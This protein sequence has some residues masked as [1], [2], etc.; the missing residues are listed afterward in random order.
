M[1]KEWASKGTLEEFTA[2]ILVKIPE[3]PHLAPDP[4]SVSEFRPQNFYQIYAARRELQAGRI[5]FVRHPFVQ[6]LYDDY[7][8]LINKDRIDERNIFERGVEVH[9]ARDGITLTD[10][11]Y[12]AEYELPDDTTHELLWYREGVTREQRARGIA[13]NLWL[14]GYSPLD[15][16]V[17]VNPTNWR[18]VHTYE[19]DHLFVRWEGGNQHFK[20]F[21]NPLK[22]LHVI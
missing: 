6:D 7:L 17:L 2:A 20:P 21:P 22:L 9:T 18:S 13:A 8:K 14:N 11:S 10:V 16:V 1:N 5:R 15:V 4:S 12:L 3:V 19:H